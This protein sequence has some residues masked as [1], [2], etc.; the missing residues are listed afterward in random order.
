MQLLDRDVACLASVEWQ[1]HE[2]N[3][4]VDIE[5]VCGPEW[6]E[7]YLLTPQERW[8]QTQRLW[9]IYLALGGTLA[10]EPDMQ[11]PF[12]DAEEW[13]QDAVDGRPSLRAIRRSGV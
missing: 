10:P 3:S 8:A 11:S 9:E 13:C 5:E 2:G 7:W 4:M 12:F 6:A 1:G